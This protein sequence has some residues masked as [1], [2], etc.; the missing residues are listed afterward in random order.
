[1]NKWILSS[2]LLSLSI[3]SQN[4]SAIP[5][6]KDLDLSGNI[7]V[8]SSYVYRGATNS[9]ENDQVTLQGL[10][11]G[12]YKS[13]YTAYFISN[14]GYSYKELQGNKSYPSDK[15]EQDFILGYIYNYDSLA[16]EL[17]NA[18]YY[19]SGGRNTTGNETSIKI[20][21]SFSKNIMTYTLAS[22]L[23]NDT[24]YSNKGDSFFGINFIYNLNEM[25]NFEIGS[26]FSYFNDHGKFEGGN[27]LNTQKNFAFRYADAKINYHLVPYLNGYIQH[28]VG[29]ND[30][31]GADMKNATVMGLKYSF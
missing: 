26:G 5:L 22:Y 1:M 13:F 12:S 19:Y 15:Y 27:F 29:G 31:A 28:I 2:S 7:S 17:S 8:L 4:A 21:Q 18:T 6:S 11:V 3:G 23:F 20:T 30:R 14:L 24:V 10:V 9:P 16:V 25:M